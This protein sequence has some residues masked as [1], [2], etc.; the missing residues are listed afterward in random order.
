[1]VRS[2]K[3]RDGLFAVVDCADWEDFRSTAKQ[4]L[5]GFAGASQI[6]DRYLF[7][8]QSCSTWGLESSFD[9]RHSTLSA[10]ARDAKYAESLRLFK[11]NYSAYGE[12]A[13]TPFAEVFGAFD[14]LK[15]PEIEALAQHFGMNTKLLDWS[16]SMYVAAFFAVSRTDL[17][18]SGLVSVW[19]LDIEAFKELSRK[20]VT[21]VRDFYKGNVRNLWQ[22]A[23]FTR[24]NTS[25]A[26]LVDIF[27]TTSS[28]Y[29]HNLDSGNPALI[30]FDFPKDVEEDLLDDLQ[31][32]RINSMTIFPGIEGVINWIKRKAF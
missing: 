13:R 21:F 6:S 2:F 26:D 30:R 31:M 32:M 28:S 15:D 27:R 20:E 16:L 8:G 10:A 12:M 7:R 11:E 14:K 19:S 25:R 18:V 17:C 23:A 9:R 1:M 29:D 4:M 22:M 5:Q 3:H 24:N